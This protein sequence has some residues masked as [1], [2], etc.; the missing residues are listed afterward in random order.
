MILAAT[1]RLLLPWFQP[2]AA[3]KRVRTNHACH[4]TAPHHA[5]V[6]RLSLIDRRPRNRLNRNRPCQSA[7]TG[8]KTLK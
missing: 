6:K 7:G 1:A 8:G 4:F 3:V 5:R 2:P